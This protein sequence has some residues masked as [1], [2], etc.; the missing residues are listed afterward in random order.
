MYNIYFRYVYNIPEYFRSTKTGKFKLS[1]SM[2][3]R[4]FSKVRR[5]GIMIPKA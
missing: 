5:N 3:Y 2:K 1:L 4:K